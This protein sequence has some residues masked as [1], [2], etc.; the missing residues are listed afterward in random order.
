M[1]RKRKE[2]RKD[3]LNL[4]HRQHWPVKYKSSSKVETKIS[5]GWMACQHCGKSI[6]QD[7]VLVEDEAKKKGD[8]KGLSQF[9]ASTTLASKIQEFVESGNEDIQPCCEECKLLIDEEIAKQTRDAELERD[10]YLSFQSRMDTGSRDEEELS[11]KREIE[12]LGSEQRSLQG[13]LD[14]L[15]VSRDLLEREIQEIDQNGK[16]FSLE[17]QRYWTKFS[18]LQGKVSRHQNEISHMKGIQDYATEEIARLQRKNVYQDTFYITTST[19]I[20][21]INGLKFGRLPK[22]QVDW[23]EINA[24]WGEVALL[25]YIISK[26]LTPFEFKKYRLKPQGN[27]STIEEH[28]PTGNVVVYDLF[29]SNDLG[30]RGWFQW[31]FSKSNVN[32]KFDEGLIAFLFCVQQACAT[33]KERSGNTIE[34]PYEMVNDK[35]DGGSIQTHSGT[36]EQWTKALKCLL[37]NL[38]YLLSWIGS[39]RPTPRKK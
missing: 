35:I 24:A 30:F 4:M 10:T 11:L 22:E 31:G 20:A 39:N 3:Y 25:L 15:N 19:D 32:Q 5:F 38:N 23:E 33:I 17:E 27:R 18:E 12:K 21:T 1:K 2:M 37:T 29:G 26:K 9:D 8:A 14:R 7:F 28:Q 6:T 16:V 36:E 13:I 34:V